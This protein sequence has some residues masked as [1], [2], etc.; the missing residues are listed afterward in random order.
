MVTPLSFQEG[1]RGEAKD[2]KGITNRALVNEVRDLGLNPN[3]PLYRDD[4]RGL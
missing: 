1:R 3:K 2:L 4:L